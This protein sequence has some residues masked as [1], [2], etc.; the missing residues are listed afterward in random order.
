M[1]DKTTGDANTVIGQY[2]MWNN[3]SGSTNT[4]LGNRTGYWNTG[5]GNVF[6]GDSA[7]YYETGSDKLY[8][9]N[10]PTSTPL[11]YGDFSNNYL[12]VNDSLNVNGRSEFNHSALFHA[13][14]IADSLN[15]RNDTLFIGSTVVIAGD[16][17]VVGNIDYSF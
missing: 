14:I 9:D 3:V 8:I 13:G 10:T 17:D 2:A 16:M 7:A 12:V 1:N 6:V 5:S 11:L 15:A 4:T